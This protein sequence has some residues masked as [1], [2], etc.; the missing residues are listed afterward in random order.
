LCERQD[1]RVDDMAAF[2]V[3]CRLNAGG[4]RHGLIQEERGSLS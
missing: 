2:A 1:Q 3:G 4:A